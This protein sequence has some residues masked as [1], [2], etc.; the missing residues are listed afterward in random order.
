MA[1]LGKENIQILP[2]H[3]VKHKQNQVNAYEIIQPILNIKMVK[4]NQ[5]VVEGNKQ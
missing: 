3:Q 2:N 4:W 1:S 5:K